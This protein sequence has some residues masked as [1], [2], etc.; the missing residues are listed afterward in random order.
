MS[1]FMFIIRPIIL[2]TLRNTACNL[3]LHSIFKYSFQAVKSF[4]LVCRR[5][6]VCRF[7]ITNSVTEL[8]GTTF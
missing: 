5:I 7:L 2:Y 8:N 4:K 3:Y 6:L 1:H